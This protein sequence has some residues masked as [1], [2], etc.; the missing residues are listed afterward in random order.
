MLAPV[1]LEMFGENGYAMLVDEGCKMMLSLP[2][3]RH[4]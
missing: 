1:L 4:S 3:A 2:P